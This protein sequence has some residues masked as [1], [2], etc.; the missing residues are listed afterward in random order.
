MFVLIIDGMRV[1][2]PQPGF[3]VG[4]NVH[5]NALKRIVHHIVHELFNRLGKVL[6]LYLLAHHRLVFLVE[7]LE[8]GPLR[9]HVFPCSVVQGYITLV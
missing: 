9:H 3:P 5:I 7:Y 1:E 8:I 2:M 6:V 4:N